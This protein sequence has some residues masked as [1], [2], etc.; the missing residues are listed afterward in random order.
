MRPIKTLCKL[1]QYTLLV[2]LPVILLCNLYMIVTKAPT[3][4][5]WSWAIVLSGSMEPEIHTN[6]LIVNKARDSYE[7][8]D[9]IT[10][11]TGTA[12]IT[13]R[14]VGES[15]G[16]FITRG[17][18]NNVQDATPVPREHILG[19]LVFTIP[20]IGLIA[21]FLKTPLGMLCMVIAGLCSVEIP[22]LLKTHK[23]KRE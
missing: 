20:N 3:L 17:D 23:N 6:D 2:L 5:G 10:F 16:G 22:Y 4:F 13:H 8:G 9:I 12:L 15:E 11:K 7:T 14:I 21:G 19:R 1:L 18:A